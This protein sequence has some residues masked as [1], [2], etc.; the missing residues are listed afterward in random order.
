VP[1]TSWTKIR[2]SRTRSKTK[3]SLRSLRSH[4]EREGGHYWGSDVEQVSEV[5]VDS[6]SKLAVN[7]T[8][9]HRDTLR[10]FVGHYSY[11]QMTV[12]SYDR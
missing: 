9:D 12:T 2:L 5:E 7:S 1:R 11:I 3:T 6:V 10:Q 8:Q 4:S